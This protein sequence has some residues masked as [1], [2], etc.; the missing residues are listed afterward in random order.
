MR[1]RAE[2]QRRGWPVAALI[3]KIKTQNKNLPS[4]WRV[5]REKP[6][7]KPARSLMVAALKVKSRSKSLG[8]IG[9]TAIIS[10]QR[11]GCFRS[12]VD[13]P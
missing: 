4:C 7:R 6:S 11:A 1:Y 5:V 9:M 8:K 10:L 12:W 13:A 3:I 2:S